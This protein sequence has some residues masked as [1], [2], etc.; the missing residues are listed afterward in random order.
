[1]GLPAGEG[2]VV[3]VTAVAVSLALSHRLRGRAH[4]LLRNAGR[5]GLGLARQVGVLPPALEPPRH[6]PI[7]VVAHEARRLGQRYRETRRGVSY[8]KS[9]AV[10]RAY[11]D[12]LA[13]GCD[14][15]GI[16]HLLGVIDDA[17]EL[18]AER[19]R[20]ERLLHVWGLDLDSPPEAA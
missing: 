17:A 11:D 1:M 18:D 10:R 2:A 20:V 14:A 8:A 9:E 19:L 7:E 16:A 13:E 3:V 5:A 6:R 4:V 15:L 12:V